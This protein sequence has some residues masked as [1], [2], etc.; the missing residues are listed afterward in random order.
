MPHARRRHVDLPR[1]RC[2]VMAVVARRLFP[3]QPAQRRCDGSVPALPRCVAVDQTRVSHVCAAAGRS[4]RR[5][6][7]ARAM[8]VRRRSFAR[9]RRS[10]TSTRSPEWSTDSNSTATASTR[11]CSVSC[12]RTRIGAAYGG[13][14]L[15]QLILPVPLS[16]ARLLRRGHN[17]AALLARWVGDALALPVDYHAC[18]R[19]RNTPPQTGLSRSARLRNLDWRV[20]CRS[21]ARGPACRD[22]RR[23]DDDRQHRHRARARS[24]G[25]G[26]CRSARVERGPNAWNR[27]RANKP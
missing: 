22:T 26:R 19:V 2:A 12:W 7:A 13:D 16:R 20:C 10:R 5:C 15:P 11:A 4:P 27:I 23:R 24:A 18:R 9:F 1:T 8:R 6:G 3:V 14:A 25:S 17:Q 21:S